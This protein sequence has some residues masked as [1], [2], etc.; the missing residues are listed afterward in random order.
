MKQAAY[1]CHGMP[2]LLNSSCWPPSIYRTYIYISILLMT[3]IQ[4]N[5]S[6]EST[7]TCLMNTVLGFKYKDHWVFILIYKRCLYSR[8]KWYL[9]RNADIFIRLYE[10]QAV[11][12]G[13]I[14][15]GSRL[16]VSSLSETRHTY[17][18][19]PSFHQLF[20]KY[21]LLYGSVNN[22]S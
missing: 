12:H 20:H 4:S 5:R 7:H 1:I 6:T 8:P 10:Q 22:Q 2:T 14:W 17:Y 13:N 16:P 9:A 3:T 15:R 11:S 18:M 19:S 21:A